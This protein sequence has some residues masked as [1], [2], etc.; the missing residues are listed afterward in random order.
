MRRSILAPLA[1]GG[2]A[3]ATGGWFLQRGVDQE[4]NVY[5]QEKLFDE[6]VNRVSDSFVDKKEPS[7]LYQMAI[8]GLLEELGDPHT[9][10]MT[11]KD[12]TTLKVQTQ[13]EY[14]G[15]GMQI[16][17]RD[18]WITVI[19]P[20]PNTPAERA[21]VLSGDQITEFNG[22][23]TKEWDEDLAVN[24]LRG[25][26]GTTI[27]LKVQRVGVEQPI[28]FKI[29]RDEIRVRAVPSSYML[30]GNVGYAELSVF[31]ESATDELRAAINALRKQGAKGMILDLRNNPGGLLDQGVTVSDLFLNR[32]QLV[33]ETKSRVPNQNQKA[34]ASD[35]DEYP[36]LPVVVLVGPYS[37]SAAEIVA[38]A[39]QDHDRALVIGRTTYGKG[40]VQQ[41]FPLSNQ[42]YLKMTTARWYTPVGRSIQRPYGIGTDGT[43]ATDDAP[44][45]GSE[46]PANDTTKKPAFK[47][48]G[49]R[50]VYGGGGI[51]PDIIVVDSLTTSERALFESLQKHWPKF[52]DTR[53]RFGV[54][55]VREH[56]DLQPGFA[57]TPEI[58][59]AF[60][61]ALQDGGVSIDRRIY[62]AG[63][64]WIRTQ[65]AYEISN[66]KW[67]TQEARKRVNAESQEVAVAADLLRRAQTPQ[68]LFKVGEAFNAEQKSKMPGAK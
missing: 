62:D 58:L 30:E 42:N 14:G 33:V 54:R 67:G 34:L 47:T 11:P 20:L 8:D 57:V 25:P 56:S 19:A 59:D 45:S 23:T 68:G 12:Y 53:F 41:V 50:T 31:S 5:V 51:H 63:V 37:A 9:S 13:G 32:G 29:T 60:H 65:L 40:S 2:I 26:K 43:A 28:T 4:Q 39:L 7:Q 17:K 10:F 36:G 49:G 38:G 44:A 18:G 61:K 66:S 3:L 21:G 35:P 52:L 22:K 48:D 6:V 15:L 55:W 27:E 16:G 24:T 46:A 64:A 1:V